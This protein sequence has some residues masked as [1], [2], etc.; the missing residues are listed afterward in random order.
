MD[1]TPCS[2]VHI[3][4]RFGGALV[5]MYQSTR[6]QIN[7]TVICTVSEEIDL[8]IYKVTAFDVTLLT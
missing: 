2:L 8:L 6:C 3:C 7:E 5:C 1:V 4:Q